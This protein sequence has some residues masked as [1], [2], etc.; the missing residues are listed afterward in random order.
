MPTS[1]QA[2]AAA[3][4]GAE[5]LYSMMQATH[6]QS[7]ARARPSTFTSFADAQAQFGR[8]HLQSALGGRGGGGQILAEGTMRDRERP[9]RLHAPAHTTHT[10]HEAVGAG[11]ATAE[12]SS[13]ITAPS[14]PRKTQFGDKPKM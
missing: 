12:R 2:V 8:E 13:V 4:G 14:E 11:Q 1:T 10:P 7:Q 6:Q 5:Q 9:Q 3:Q